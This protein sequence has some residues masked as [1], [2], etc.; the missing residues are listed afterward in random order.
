MSSE[1]ITN[2]VFPCDWSENKDQQAACITAREI[3]QAVRAKLTE[4]EPV[5]TL[6]VDSVSGIDVTYHQFQG[7]YDGMK[8]YAHPM[9]N[10]ARIKEALRFAAQVIELYDDATL[11][12]DNY[13]LTSTD[14][15]EI[16]KELVDYIPCVST[17]I[18]KTACVSENGESET[19]TRGQGNLDSSNHIADVGKMVVP[20]GWQLVPR[21]LDNEMRSKFWEADEKYQDGL[22]TMPDAGYKAM[23]AA[24][25]KFGEE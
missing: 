9:P 23:L 6:K 17:A 21:E 3:E 11:V 2:I 19:Q 8:L 4:Q 1:E 15:A 12:S 14:C 22:A 13:M 25:P 20:D 7:L 18:D 24:A 5:A 16:I 10:Q